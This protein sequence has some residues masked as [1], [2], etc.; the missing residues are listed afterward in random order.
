MA[1]IWVVIPTYWGP[2]NLGVYDHP[3]PIDGES[4]LPRLLDSLIVQESYPHFS[5]LILV[6]AVAE[7]YQV[8]ATERVRRLLHPYQSKLDIFI[9]DAETAG[10]VSELLASQNLNP[11]VAGMRGYAAVR[12]LQLLVPAAIGAQIIVAL[13]DDEVVPPDYVSQAIKWVGNKF[14][15]EYIYGVAGPYL[16]ESGSPYLSE[17]DQVSNFLRDKSVFINQ[18]MRKLQDS[19][20]K[21][22]ST[23]M[24][25]G[26][27]MVFH[28]ELFESVCFD[29]AIT[30]GEDIDYVINARIAGKDFF[31]DPQL[32]ITHL[33][34]RHYEAPEYAKLRQDIY[35]FIYEA[36]KLRIAGL[37]AEDFG[38]Y[39]GRM[40]EDDFIQAARDALEQTASPSLV[41]Q[42][43]DPEYIIGQAQDYAQLHAHSYFAYAE[44]W[45]AL[46]RALDQLNCNMSLLTHVRQ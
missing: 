38:V 27:N 22:M 32:T 26:G 4:T 11:K 35:R 36:E 16:D 13:D 33:P 9:A 17:P 24:A 1:D 21:L 15:G 44:Q 25:F 23:G 37:S 2:T 34:P 28:R 41:R 5:T 30:R 46:I 7:E 8:S 12:N 43:G 45:P 42:F 29:P 31:F 3:T 40:L 14:Q 20:D 6:S 18:A 10:L 39:P 19:P